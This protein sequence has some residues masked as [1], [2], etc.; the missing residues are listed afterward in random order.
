MHKLVILRQIIKKL[1]A[2]VRVQVILK[3]PI[4]L[5][6]TTFIL[7]YLT[8][9]NIAYASNLHFCQINF[10]TFNFQNP[11]NCKTRLTKAHTYETIFIAP[12]LLLYSTTYTKLPQTIA[13]LFYQHNIALLGLPYTP[14]P[15]QRTYTTTL[16]PNLHHSLNSYNLINTQPNT[17]PIPAYSSLVRYS[18]AAF[19]NSIPPALTSCNYNSA[20]SF[21]T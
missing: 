13:A 18:A 4:L 21:L 12:C 11:D 2:Q 17:L 8:K 6:K 10:L 5:T 15:S 7:N 1:F 16:V 14:L 19:A 9:T 3:N 20:S